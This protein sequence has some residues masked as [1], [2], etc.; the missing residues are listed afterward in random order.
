MK[1]LSTME[2]KFFLYV[3]TLCLVFAVVGLSFR[4]FGS[5]SGHS[6]HHWSYVTILVFLLTGLM[7]QVRAR[8]RERFI[9]VFLTVAYAIISVILTVFVYLRH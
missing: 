2:L 6:P 3:Q 4:E 1:F 7:V 8:S 5:H 9:L